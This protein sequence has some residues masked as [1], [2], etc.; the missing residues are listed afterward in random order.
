MGE[1]QVNFE[2]VFKLPREHKVYGWPAPAKALWLD[3]ASVP[4]HI[5]CV[6][7]GYTESPWVTLAQTETHKQWHNKLAKISFE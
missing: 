2:N 7:A 3:L 4:H 6:I 1:V 5:W